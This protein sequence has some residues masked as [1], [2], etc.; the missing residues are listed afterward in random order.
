MMNCIVGGELQAMNTKRRQK[1]KSSFKYWMGTMSVKNVK[2]SFWTASK[3]TKNKWKK[4]SNYCRFVEKKFLD[5]LIRGLTKIITTCKMNSICY[6]ERT[7]WILS[8]DFDFE[9][10][11]NLRIALFP[12]RHSLYP[13]HRL[14]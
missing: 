3:T 12:W 14:K 6:F 8:I 11:N 10:W 2:L 13:W 1:T 7:F 4:Y 5:R 9:K